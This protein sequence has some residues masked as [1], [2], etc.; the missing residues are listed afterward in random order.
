[1]V[2]AM[3][4]EDGR[5]VIGNGD[6]ELEEFSEGCEEVRNSPKLSWSEMQC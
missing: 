2:P 5:S 1:M 6:R 4:I 3:I